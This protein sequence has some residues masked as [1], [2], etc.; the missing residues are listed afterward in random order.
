MKSTF[1][2]IL[3]ATAIVG[4]MIPAGIAYAAEE[5]LVYPATSYAPVYLVDGLDNVQYPA[6]TQLDWDHLMMAHLSIIP[7]PAPVT[8]EETMRLPYVDGGVQYLPFISAPGDEFSRSTWKAYGDLGNLTGGRGAK[9]P[10]VTPS[11]VA[12]G[13][14]AS[15]K[16]IGGTYSL[17][18]AYVKDTAMTVVAVFFTTI[19]VDPGVGTWKFATP[20]TKTATTTTL[21]SSSASVSLGESVTLTA[22]VSASAA[23]GNVQFL[24]ESTSLGITASAGGVATLTASSLG[25]GTHSI[26]AVYAG[27]G[28]YAGSTSAPTTVTV[29]D[30]LGPDEID[31]VPGNTGG[32]S[33]SVAGSVATITMNASLNGTLVNIFGYSTPVFLGQ[34]T[35]SGGQATVNISALTAGETHKIAVVDVGGGTIIG[36]AE[37]A[38]AAGNME[39]MRDLEAVVMRSDDG[40]FY[41]IAPDNSTPALIGSPSLVGGQSFSTGVLGEFSVVDERTAS[42]PGWELTTSVENFIMGAETIS[43]SALGLD[44][45]M[46]GNTGPGAPILGATQVAGSAIYDSLFAELAAGAYD[47]QADFNAD[48]SF[49]APLG[50]VPGTYTSVLTLTLVSK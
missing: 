37:F 1:V 36:W 5:P 32:V 22:T 49:L 12:Y 3:A 18:V 21:S 14:S 44:P 10:T 33:I 28:T 4:L 7:V 35:V 13:D 11:Y 8:D 34:R 29:N 40:E 20:V 31:L 27:D 6:G 39:G 26:T 25:V 9:L 16:A 48:L 42:K 47:D 30:I 23:T 41:L 15:V 19:N 46:V 24:D 45:R 50:A 17:G 2:K 43:K 38:I